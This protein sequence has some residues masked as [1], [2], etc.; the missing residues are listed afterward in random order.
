[1]AIILGQ[2]FQFDIVGALNHGSLSEH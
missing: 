2:A 1:V